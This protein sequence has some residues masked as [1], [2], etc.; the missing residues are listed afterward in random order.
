MEE[1]AAVTVDHCH[2]R[3]FVAVKVEGF[4]KGLLGGVDHTGGNAYY[5]SVGQAVE[6]AVGNV[7]SDKEHHTAPLAERIAVLKH[8]LD[9]VLGGFAVR[10]EKGKDATRGT[11]LVGK[12]DAIHEFEAFGHLRERFSIGHAG[13]ERKQNDFFSDPFACFH[14]EEFHAAADGA[15]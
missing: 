8:F 7:G 10:A 9:E 6:L 13:Y 1:Y 15:V 5:V 3:I 11:G 14:F 4:G 2:Q 12:V